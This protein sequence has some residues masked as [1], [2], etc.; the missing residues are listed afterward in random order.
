MIFIHLVQLFSLEPKFIYQLSDCCLFCAHFLC[1][2][3]LFGLIFFD[4]FLIIL[5]LF[6]MIVEL[7][8]F[9]FSE[10]FGHLLG[11]MLNHAEHRVPEIL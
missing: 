3:T 8:S 1:Q 6:D 4:Q 9:L 5:M 2:M 11:D 10:M 7:V